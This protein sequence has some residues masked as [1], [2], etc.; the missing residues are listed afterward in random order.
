MEDQKHHPF[1]EKQDD[2]PRKLPNNICTGVSTGKNRLCDLCRLID[3]A[4]FS[5]QAPWQGIKL[6]LISH[7]RP[8]H[9]S[10]TCD[11][12]PVIVW[13]KS[14]KR[15]N[16]K[17]RD[18]DL[19]YSL[20]AC[21]V[22]PGGAIIPGPG[23]ARGTLHGFLSLVGDEYTSLSLTWQNNYSARFMAVTTHAAAEVVPAHPQK[24]PRLRVIDCSTAQLTAIPPHVPYVALSYLWGP[25]TAHDG[26]SRDKYN[27]KKAPATIRDAMKATLSLGYTYLWVD[28][29]CIDQDNPVEKLKVI[30]QMGQ[31]YSNALVTI[32]AAAGSDPHHGLPGVGKPRRAPRLDVIFGRHRIYSL[33]DHPHKTIES[34]PWMTRGW[35]YQEVVL[36]Q[37]RCYFTEDQV[38]LE[39]ETHSFEDCFAG[40]LNN[41][42]GLFFDSEAETWRLPRLEI[43]DMINAYSKRKM[44]FDSDYL[45]GFAGV[46]AVKQCRYTWGVPLLPL[47]WRK[48]YE[49]LGEQLMLGMRWLVSPSTGKPKSCGY[50][51]WSWL[52]WTGEVRTG[53]RVFLAK[54]AEARLLLPAGSGNQ[55]ETVGHATLNLEKLYFQCAPATE[56]AY[57]DFILEYSLPLLT[58]ETIVLV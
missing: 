36:S 12:C 9:K 29:Y 28:R 57:T 13:L 45:D 51:T 42:R 26:L 58:F 16:N 46:L 52:A 38:L 23:S 48:P 55:H 21:R 15:D 6:A 11:F 5:R 19:M 1:P 4:Q 47:I 35:T 27:F 41:R 22:G 3:F 39:S 40:K 31:I 34:S 53:K 2:P 8:L 37:A 44:S 30:Q 49:S 18:L 20:A 10:L 56:S 14:G 24:I 7:D 17:G 32:V 33:P 43:Y 25:A 50:P 54:Y